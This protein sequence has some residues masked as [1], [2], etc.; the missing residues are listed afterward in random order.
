M[1]IEEKRNEITKMLKDAV[2]EWGNSE[3]AKKYETEFESATFHDKE[4]SD[5]YLEVYCDYLISR[6]SGNTISLMFKGP[7]R[8]SEVRKYAACLKN[9]HLHTLAVDL[10]NIDFLNKVFILQEEGFYP[11]SIQSMK[12]EEMEWVNVLIL[13]WEE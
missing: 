12:N 11:T 10:D 13:H 3:F 2:K 6:N 9:E 7:W 8:T 4:D 1:T 5:S